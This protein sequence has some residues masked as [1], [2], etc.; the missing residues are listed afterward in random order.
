MWKVYLPVFD[1]V[2]FKLSENVSVRS[3]RPF[4]YTEKQLENLQFCIDRRHPQVQMGTCLSNTAVCRGPQR[5]PS[6]LNDLDRSH[7]TSYP[8]YSQEERE[9][10]FLR[11]QV[12]EQQHIIDDLSKVLIFLLLYSYC[13]YYC[14]NSISMATYSHYYY[15]HCYYY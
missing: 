6:S 4:N 3:N 14:S 2:C 8:G 7:S 10:E 9:M 15:Y 1:S 5:R 11:L 13:Y 12:L